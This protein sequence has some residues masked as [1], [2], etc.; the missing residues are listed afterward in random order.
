MEEAPITARAPRSR[1]NGEGSV[2]QDNRGRWRARIKVD[3]KQINRFAPTKTEA[4]RIL[5]ELVTDSD[6]GTPHGDGSL[7]LAAV[8]DRWAV[9]VLP[10]LGLAP[11]TVTVNRWALGVL[12]TD[13]GSKRLTVLTPEAVELAFGRRA[14]AGMSRESLIKLRSVLSKVLAW[15][16]RRQYVTRNVA[17]LVDLPAAAKRTEAGR[18]LD[19]EQ[20]RALLKAV[21]DHRL[22]ALWIVML[23]LGLR[24]GEATGLQW[25]DIDVD[26][27]LIHVRRSLKLHDGAAVVTDELKT[28]RARRSLDAPP[29]VISALRAHR[30]KQAEERLKAG[31]LW[32]TEWPGQ[33]FT[34]TIGTL[35]RPENVRKDLAKLTAAAGLGR[36]H[37]NELRHSC[38]SILSAAGV[39]LEH[40]A[41]V[42]GHDGTRM[43]SL[44]YRHAVSPSV[45]GAL[46]MSAALQAK[47]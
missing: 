29:E 35:I 34:T 15:A 4:K 44:V 22:A 28:S 9:T 40:I 8:I 10:G 43:T 13:L 41:D 21:D 3:G 47:A 37:P 20:A 6:K 18:A 2:F 1:G 39:P 5:R 19:V 27:A 46:A 11:P 7:T 33:V 32:S 38:A 14:D 24:P 16:E 31:A 36:W 45:G 42:L 17:K 25:I 12:T 30:V 23:M 26:Q